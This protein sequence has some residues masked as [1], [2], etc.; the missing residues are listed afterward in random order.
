MT[1]QINPQVQAMRILTIK[2]G[3][4]AELQ[5]F[6]LTAKAP[7]CFKI[8]TEEFGIKVNNKDKMP[9]YLTFC[10]AFGLKPLAFTK[11]LNGK[12]EAI[13]PR[14]SSVGP[15]SDHDA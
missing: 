5:G 11:G 2:T 8:I 4:E 10:T 13:Y 7:R 1:M 3:L 12:Y 14:Q 9:A 6:R 15:L